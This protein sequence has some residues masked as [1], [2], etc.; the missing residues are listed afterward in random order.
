[1]ALRAMAWVKVVSSVSHGAWLERG[2]RTILVLLL[3]PPV[4]GKR[5]KRNFL[6]NVKRQNGVGGRQHWGV[7]FHGLLP[8]SWCSPIK[9]KCNIALTTGVI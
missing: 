2:N 5:W 3:L 1:M 9:A 8:K 7:F 4:F 6:R